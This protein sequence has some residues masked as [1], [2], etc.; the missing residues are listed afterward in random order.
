MD[1][2]DEIVELLESLQK[3]SSHTADQ[4]MSKLRDKA[5]S[6]YKNVEKRL[7]N[8]LQTA[9]PF[10]YLGELE[11]AS[12]MD[13]YAHK[14]FE[15]VQG[16]VDAHEKPDKFTLRVLENV[17]EALRQDM[18][19]QDQQLI[20]Y[21]KLLKGK[22]FEKKLKPLSKA[23]VKMNDDLVRLE[24][25]TQEEYTPNSEIEETSNIIEDLIADL[26][27]YE[28]LYAEIVSK[29]EQVAEKN[30]EIEQLNSEIDDILNHPVKKEYQEVSDDFSDFQRNA[31]NRFSNIRKALRKYEN[32][33]SKMKDKPDLT[34]LRE[35]M[36]DFAL[37]LA[38]QGSPQGVANLLSRVNTELDNSSLQLKKD[39]RD[40][41]RDDINSLNNGELNSLWNE[42]RT[43][44]A[45]KTEL[46]TK[47]KELDLEDKEQKLRVTLDGAKRDR[48]RIIE[49]ELRDLQK[50]TEQIEK[51]SEDLKPRLEEVT[52]KASDFEITLIE[53][54]EWVFLME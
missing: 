54:P 18:A 52:N 37:C 43:K 46:E 44:L 5:D 36:K 11:E 28:R 1:Q 17:I 20:K 13:K 35:V 19:D 41:I 2:L 9:E 50:L 31:E 38:N 15:T 42:A 53:L 33:A 26:K 45:K 8:M 39:K 27:A 34:L 25:F 48:N 7:H 16:T 51:S 47:L 49:R 4:A 40:A 6:R 32:A 21:V 24:R 14:I 12:A 22:K 23:I 10:K 3:K 29:N 30:K